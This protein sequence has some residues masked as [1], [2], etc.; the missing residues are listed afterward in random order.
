MESFCVYDLDTQHK[1]GPSVLSI[2]PKQ[3]FWFVVCQRVKEAKMRSGWNN[4]VASKA[5]RE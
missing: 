3:H 1:R 5:T 4:M 2:P